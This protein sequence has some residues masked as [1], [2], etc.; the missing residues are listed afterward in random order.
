MTLQTVT[1]SL[2]NVPRITQWPLSHIAFVAGCLL[3][4]L[5]SV[6]TPD[7]PGVVEIIIATLLGISIIA[8]GALKLFSFVSLSNQRPYWMHAGITFMAFAITV[9]V[10]TGIVHGNGGLA[11][12]RDLIGLMFWLLPVFFAVSVFD[13]QKSADFCSIVTFS[14]TAI[15]VLFS[16]RFLI[17]LLA[18]TEKLTLAPA[19]PD[20]YLELVNVPSVLFAA[21]YLTGHGLRKLQYDFRD[22]IT[23]M[24]YLFI[25][26]LP[27]IAGISALQRAN[28]GS[29]FILLF[30]LIA[31]QIYFRHKRSIWALIVLSIAITAIYPLLS[32]VI[33]LMIEKTRLVGFNMRFEEANA[34]LNH[35]AR[36][37]GSFFLGLGWG[38]SFLSPA[39]GFIE[40]NFTHNFFMTLWLKTGIAGLALGSL[41][42]VA[43]IL[44]IFRQ[45]LSGPTRQTHF[46]M[47][48]ALFLP[49][50]IN[51]L[52]YANHKSFDFG[53]MLLLCALV[54]HARKAQKSS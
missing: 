19:H 41:Y 29:L 13:K 4:G 54:G 20:I 1:T 34:I 11:I 47:T 6:P 17:S 35:M 36:Y 12:I 8:S 22:K 28:M 45:I 26:C 2:Y 40:I 37:S 9:P 51:L 5:Y 30:C 52:L 43:L 10:I 32:D 7:N 23:G 53:L 24:I 16:I 46:I 39:A 27:V 31:I 48:L 14:I 44:P 42:V 25:G 15:G 18:V 38:A 3:Y 21:L 33:S 49:V 50:I